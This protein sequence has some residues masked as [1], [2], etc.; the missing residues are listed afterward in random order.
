M[1]HDIGQ[2][3]LQY[4]VGAGLHVGIEG[5]AQA[6]G[7]PVLSALIRFGCRAAIKISEKV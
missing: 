2:R 3:L 4:P 1:A 5:A 7:Y 6:P